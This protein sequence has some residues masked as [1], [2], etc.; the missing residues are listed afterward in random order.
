MLRLRRPTDDD[1]HAVLDAAA[2]APFTYAEV[3]A[4][5]GATMP[6]G[7]HHGTE[8]AVVGQ[9]DATF[10]RAAE[11]LRRWQAHAGIGAQVH[12]AG[13]PVEVG[14]VVATVLRVGPAWMVAPCRIAYVVDEPDRFGFAYGTLP[15]HPESGEE[16][17]VVSR[18]ATGE[19]RFDVRVFSRHAALVTKLS[20]PVGTFLQRRAARDYV[21]GIRRFVAG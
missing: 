17:F 6:A 15:G 12:P 16:A 14:T 18:S 21:D 20:G 4:T 10:A 13:A 7:Y 3:G 19:V 2:E 5:R 8:G 11:G 1:L 9:G